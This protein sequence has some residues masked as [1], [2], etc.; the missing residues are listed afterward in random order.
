MTTTL[1]IIAIIALI[2][3]VIAIRICIF[4]KDSE[5]HFTDDEFTEPKAPAT[6]LPDHVEKFL[7]EYM[8]VAQK[9]VVQHTQK[10]CKRVKKI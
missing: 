7:E 10:V 5:P 4:C 2:V 1:L 6:K 3:T 8:T 9:P